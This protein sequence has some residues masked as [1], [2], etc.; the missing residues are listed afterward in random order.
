MLDQHVGVVGSENRVKKLPRLIFTYVLDVCID[1]NVDGC[2]TEGGAGVNEL[3]GLDPGQPITR[4]PGRGS[5]AAVGNEVFFF[6]VLG[7]EVPSRNYGHGR[8]PHVRPEL[9]TK[10][11]GTGRSHSLSLSGDQI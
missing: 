4:G 7:P 5:T 11:A 10:V 6:V 9:R 8:T 1:W 2:I 3:P